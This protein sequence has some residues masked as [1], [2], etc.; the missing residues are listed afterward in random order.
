MGALGI[1]CLVI[2]A[3]IAIIYGLQLL[4]MAFRESILWGLGYLF[5][6]L[7]SLLFV[8]VHWGE[9]KSPFLKGFM[10]LPFYLCGIFLMDK[11]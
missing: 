5:I 3:L 8:I 2:G 10:A 4:I 6:P 7:V 11:A 1:V 9:A